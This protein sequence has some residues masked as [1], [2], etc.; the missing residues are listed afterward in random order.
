MK[1]LVVGVTVALAITLTGCGKGHTVTT[2]TQVQQDSAV[3]QQIVQTCMTKG[4]FLTSAGRTAIIDCIAPPGHA[5]QFEACAQQQL[6][7]AHLL[8]KS[9]RQAYLQAVVTCGENNR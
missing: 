4:S 1:K 2:N 5:P 7:G 9:G 3:A 6:S 8:N